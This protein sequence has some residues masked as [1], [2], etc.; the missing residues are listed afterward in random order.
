MGTKEYFY[1]RTKEREVGTMDSLPP[2]YLLYRP[3]LLKASPASCT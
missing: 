1:E 2:L 3:E